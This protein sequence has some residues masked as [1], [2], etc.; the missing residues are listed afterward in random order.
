MPRPT[1]HHRLEKLEERQTG[2]PETV[3]AVCLDATGLLAVD[4]HGNV[5]TPLSTGVMPRGVWRAGQNPVTTVP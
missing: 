5:T 2:G 4:A 3:G 1:H